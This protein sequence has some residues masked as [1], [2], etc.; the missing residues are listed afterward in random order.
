MKNF[1][2]W[3]KRK[4][5]IDFKQKTILPKKREVWWISVGL[6]IGVEEDG[7]NNEFERPVLVIKTFNRQCFLGIP[8]TSADKNNKKY[9]FPINHNKNEYFLILSQIRL[10]STKRLSRKIY[11]IES[12]VFKKIKDELRIIIGL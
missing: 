10:F 2:E 4:K 12:D 7:K 1:D 11:N 3:N 9:Y 5:E 8:I 6:N